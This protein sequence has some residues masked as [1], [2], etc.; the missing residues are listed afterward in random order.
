MAGWPDMGPVSVRRPISVRTMPES[1]RAELKEEV[2][3]NNNVENVDSQQYH[4]AWCY[5]RN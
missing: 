1:R 2:H 3:N 4:H 5:M